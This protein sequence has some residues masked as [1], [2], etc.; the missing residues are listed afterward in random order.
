MEFCFSKSSFGG[1]QLVFHFGTE[2][3]EEQL[4][5]TVYDKKQSKLL[6]SNSLSRSCLFQESN[7]SSRDGNSDPG[8]TGFL[9]IRTKDSRYGHRIFFREM[10]IS[11]EI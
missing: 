8:K 1:L 2:N 6:A 10:A 5:N 3:P 7:K 9:Q 11:V 4:K